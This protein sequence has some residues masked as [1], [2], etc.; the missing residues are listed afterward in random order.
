MSTVQQSRACDTNFFIDRGQGFQHS[1][2]DVD[3][4]V[5]A[6]LQLESPG[7]DDAEGEK[8]FAAYDSEMIERGAKAVQQSLTEAENSL[9]LEK[10]KQMLMMRQGHGKS[11]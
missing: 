8:V 10:V 4:Y 9:E 5:N 11:A 3:N 1:I 6:L 7:T 2:T